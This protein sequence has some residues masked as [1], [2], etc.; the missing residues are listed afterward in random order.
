MKMPLAAFA[1]LLLL[2]S[3]CSAMIQTSPTT[4]A[5]I[6]LSITAVHSSVKTGSPVLLD[7]ILANKSGHDLSM[8]SDVRGFD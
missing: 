8:V 5:T 7:V 3:F 4:N 1:S 6:S 2:S